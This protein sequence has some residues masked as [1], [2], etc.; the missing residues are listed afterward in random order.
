MQMKYLLASG[1]VGALLVSTAIGATL[2]K[3]NSTAINLYSQPDNH[4]NV[5]ASYTHQVPLTAFYREGQWVKVGNSSN[6][7]VG[8]V[9]MADLQHNVNQPA[10]T[11]VP[12]PVTQVQHTPYGN[13]KTTERSGVVNG[14]HY[15]I[16][17]SNLDTQNQTPAQRQRWQAHLAAQQQQIQQQML[18]EEH[19][20]DQ[21]IQQNLEQMDRL[22]D[23][24]NS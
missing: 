15:H 6:G 8:W 19:S 11:A 1:L 5:V 18:S 20:I 7:T 4:S 3:S 13:L 17:T 22:F 24:P 9:T 12:T 2:T 14:M 16:I 23:Q 10:I 21:Q